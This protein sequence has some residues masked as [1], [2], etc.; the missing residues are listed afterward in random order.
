MIR[1]LTT[2]RA[3]TLA[4][5][6]ALGGC[7]ADLEHGDGLEVV[8][9]SGQAL[10]LAPVPPPFSAG[11]PDN[12]APFGL[13]I[14]MWTRAIN[15]TEMAC[16]WDAGVRSIVVG[17]QV[18][19]VFRQHVEMS[20]R[21]GMVVDAYVYLY[22]SR[23]VTAQ[24]EAAV[25]LMQERS[26]A[27]FPVQRLWIDVEEA[28]D[29]DN[30]HRQTQEA[31]DVCTARGISCG[32]Y[33]GA[34]FWRGELNNT[35]DFA[36]VPLWYAWYG[37]GQSLDDWDTQHFGGWAF[38]TAKQYAGTKPMCGVSALDFNVM[39]IE[40]EP[41]YV[42]DRS[43]LPAPV[44]TPSAPVGLWPGNGE[45]WT[46]PYVKL[47]AAAQPATT[48]WSFELSRF[49]GSAWVVYNTW[50][51]PY[52]AVVVFPPANTSYRFRVR[53]DNAFGRGAWSPFST[54]HW[55]NPRL[56][57]ALSDPAPGPMPAP[58]E[59][60]APTTPPPPAS[61]PP[62]SPPPVIASDV[63]DQLTPSSGTFAFGSVVG[64]G[65]GGVA[66]ATRYEFAIEVKNSAGNFVP[67]FTYVTTTPLKA[68]APQ[69]RS[70][71]R[72]RVRAEIDGTFRASSSPASFEVR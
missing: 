6:L 11:D 4:A 55:G 3:P 60:G 14:C 43:P 19:E 53:A 38:P 70:A 64:L 46:R 72:F 67:Y 59:L 68:F 27:G 40:G 49:T 13:D 31:L 28:A 21:G 52:N 1:R 22:W 12:D 24:V 63:C 33:T 23:S 39:Q 66:R 42:L 16:F 10:V 35:Q 71:Y 32:I 45:T 37:N 54:F 15:D 8:D 30:A 69:T 25:A 20:V 65:C 44:T 5:L 29:A 61:P 2:L 36:N 57:G 58:R 47:M 51:S 17:T 7:V 62:A 56:R 50:T 34:G 48:S 18:P 9:E 26:A 41:R